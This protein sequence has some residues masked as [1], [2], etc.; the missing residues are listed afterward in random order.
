MAACVFGCDA[1]FEDGMLRVA[2][3]GTISVAPGHGETAAFA[4]FTNSLAGKTAPA[5]ST[6]NRAYFEWRN[7]KSLADHGA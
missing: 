2:A 7:A 5:F 6:H 4:A 1:L 3:A